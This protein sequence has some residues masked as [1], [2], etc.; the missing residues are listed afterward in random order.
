M[1][2]PFIFAVSSQTRLVCLRCAHELKLKPPHNTTHLA[3]C[4]LVGD[5]ISA[6]LC[7]SIHG[8]NLIFILQV[9]MGQVAQ[10]ANQFPSKSEN[11][12]INHVL[13]F[14][15]RNKQR[16]RSSYG[17]PR[18]VHAHHLLLRA[19]PTCLNCTTGWGCTFPQVYP[20][21]NPGT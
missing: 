16:T 5:L 14:L 12:R 7:K 19:S 2:Q 11:R 9:L 1:C 10:S 20:K 3:S 8:Q 15:W 18:A 13:T 17:W 21:S 6:Q 4:S